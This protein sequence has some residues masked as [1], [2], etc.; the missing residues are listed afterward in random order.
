[1]NNYRWALKQLKTLHIRLKIFMLIVFVIDMKKRL[2]TARYLIFSNFNHLLCIWHINN[3]VLIN[4]KN[5]FVIK[6]NWN[7]FFQR[8]KNVMYAS[9]KTEFQKVWN[10]FSNKYNLSHEDCVKYLIVIY[11]QDHR[12]RFVKAYT[13]QVLHFK[14]TMSSRS[15][16]EHSTQTSFESI[17]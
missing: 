11:I 14:T 1:M 7:D 17:N 12:R 2:I 13:N 10:A 3:Y 9:T 4:C 5:S 16:I 6:E 8:W 15:E